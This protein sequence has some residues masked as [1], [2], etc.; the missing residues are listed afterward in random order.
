MIV[1]RSGKFVVTTKSGN[2]TLGRHSTRE[3]A[4]R[5]LRAIEASKHR[6]GR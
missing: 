2:R 6:R 5:Q 1:K 4:L 3:K